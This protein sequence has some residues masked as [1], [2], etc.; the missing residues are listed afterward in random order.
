MEKYLVAFRM[1]GDRGS[2]LREITA[3]D[4]ETAQHVYAALQRLPDLHT[5]KLCEWRPGGEGAL[6]RYAPGY[7]VVLSASG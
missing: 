7:Y 2:R 3:T 4:H 1:S 6:G 5:I